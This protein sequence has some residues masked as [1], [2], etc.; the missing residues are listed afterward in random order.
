MRRDEREHREAS[1]EQSGVPD[2]SA[3]EYRIARGFLI[4]MGLVVLGVAA[5]SLWS[6]DL[7]EAARASGVLLIG[8]W[9][10]RNLGFLHE[11]LF[12]ADFFSR[13]THFRNPELLVAG[14][15]LALL[16]GFLAR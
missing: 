2:V 1:P 13:P 16:P 15:L 14:V 12:E 3:P 5:T 8:L 7:K 11:N 9:A 4:V 6:G 10:G